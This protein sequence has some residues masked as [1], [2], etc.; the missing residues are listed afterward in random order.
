MAA[1]ATLDVFRYADYRE[2]LRAYYERKKTQ[3]PGI[4]LRAFSR[5]VGLRS[6]NHLKLVIDGDLVPGPRDGP[7]RD[8]QLNAKSAA[9]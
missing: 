2:F 3:K 9:Q 6:P 8:R 1:R 4:S 7:E 5:R